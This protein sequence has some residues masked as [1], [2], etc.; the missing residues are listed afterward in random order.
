LFVS[1]NKS[2]LVSLDDDDAEY[3]CVDDH[4]RLGSIMAL[5]VL[6]TVRFLALPPE[7]TKPLF[8]GLR[9][10]ILTAEKYIETFVCPALEQAAAAAL[11]H[12]ASRD[13]SARLSALLDEVDAWL[14]VEDAFDRWHPPTIADTLKKLKFVRTAADTLRRPDELVDHAHPLVA[15]FND[16]AAGWIPH[17]WWAER[18]KMLSRLGLRAA[19][20]HDA[21]VAFAREIDK[22]GSHRGEA[23]D[24]LTQQRSFQ[25]VQEICRLMINTYKGVP[26]C[27]ELQ[28]LL[29]GVADL[30]IALVHPAGPEAVRESIHHHLYIQRDVCANIAPRCAPLVALVQIK[31]LLLTRANSVVV[32]CC[33]YVSRFSIL[34]RAFCVNEPTRHQVSTVLGG[35]QQQAPLCLVPFRNLVMTPECDL[36]ASG[37]FDILAIVAGMPK[38]LESSAIYARAVATDYP[39]RVHEDIRCLC[40]PK[41]V[42]MCTV[43]EQL[44]LASDIIAQAGSKV[45]L[46]CYKRANRALKSM[47]RATETSLTAPSKFVGDKARAVTTA[48]KA[49]LDALKN[50]RCL[51]I[52]VGADAVGDLS[53]E[54]TVV[55]M[56]EPVRCFRRL[57]SRAKNLPEMPLYEHTEIFSSCGRLA[58]CLGIRDEP[59]REDWAWC[60]RFLAKGV[61]DGEANPNEIIAVRVRVTSSLFAN[62]GVAAMLCLFT[63]LTCYSSASERFDANKTST[64]C[65]A[66][67]ACCVRHFFCCFFVVFCCTGNVL[68]LLHGERVVYT[69]PC[70]A[71]DTRLL[72]PRCCCAVVLLTAKSTSSM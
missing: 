72:W 62:S 30:R 40:A 49:L 41:H 54:M 8:T 11:Q 24:D 38:T 58:Q 32:S 33:T 61:A 57:P 64:T 31:D 21:M 10:K 52:V 36:L 5:D 66:C 63:M 37:K 56:V 16:Q 55:R 51:P 70:H 39:D 47:L 60:T 20:S 23:P 3:V 59:N 2:G 45:D 28:S 50:Q 1:A 18:I 71:H 35:T 9:V 7:G 17:T 6:Q 44:R 43:L 19:P 13:S 69:H 42:D 53:A 46:G 29:K 4:E 12:D 27:E 48:E 34:T 25:L 14:T 68:F 26:K 67:L 15:L 22:V 65:V